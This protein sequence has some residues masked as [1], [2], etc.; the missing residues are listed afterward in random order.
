L[1]RLS[2]QLT[3]L[4]HQ[5]ELNE[6]KTKKDFVELSKILDEKNEQ[7]ENEKEE[8]GNS[9]EKLESQIRELEGK[10]NYCESYVDKFNGLSEDFTALEKDRERL[11]GELENQKM[12]NLE[13]GDENKRLEEIIKG[14]VDEMEKLRVNYSEKEQELIREISQLREKVNQFGPYLNDYHEKCNSFDDLNCKFIQMESEKKSIY[15]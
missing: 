2:T 10:L 11:A 12:M 14:K 5:N 1:Q 3:N 8:F 15:G 6:E 13:K 7:L 9:K 4:T